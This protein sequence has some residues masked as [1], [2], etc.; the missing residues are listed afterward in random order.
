MREVS[1]SPGRVRFGTA[2]VPGSKSHTIRALFV[3]SLAQGESILSGALESEDTTAARRVLR[4]LGVEIGVEGGIWSIGGQAGAFKPSAEPLDVGESGLTARHL[5]AVAPLIEGRTTIVG[6]GRLPYRPMDGLLTAV[7]SQ[8]ARVGQGYP[9]QISGLGWL[10]GGILDVAASE[11]SQMI[12]A[13]LATAPLAR[14]TT[15]VRPHGWEGST[16]YVTMSIDVMERFGASVSAEDGCFVV[17]PSG[18]RAA[19]YTI[20]P[21]ASAAVYPFTAAA[22]T[23]TGVTVPGDISGHPDRVILD[24]L[25]HMGCEVTMTPTSTNLR[26]PGRL[27]AVEVDMSGAPDAAVA[28]AI[29]AAVA[30]GTSHISGLGSLRHKESDRLD[31]LQQ[32]LTKFGAEVS[33]GAESITISSRSAAATTFDSHNDHRMAM[34]L[35][36]LGL[37]REGIKIRGADAVNKTWPGFWEWLARSGARVE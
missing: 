35:A 31:A 1:I 16:G 20:P 8:G 19:P 29:A 25:G 12:S 28:V 34:S 9:W 27:A 21:D 7:I 14:S 26:G 32:E 11:S 36:L 30:E 17:E 23:G 22:I 24:V 5:V 10:P 4:Q 6:R 33:V 2:A 3:G 37:V 18:Y 15:T 13:L